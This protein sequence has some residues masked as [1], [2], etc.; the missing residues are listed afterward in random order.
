MAKSDGKTAFSV[1]SIMVA[2]FP[3]LGASATVDANAPV[4]PYITSSSKPLTACLVDHL[5][6][7][8]ACI[9]VVEKECL[10]PM[11]DT[12]T[13][14]GEVLC[15]DTEREIWSQRLAASAT[16]MRLVGHWHGSCA[17]AVCCV[18][19]GSARLRLLN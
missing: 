9:G 13:L 11:E 3:C 6:S 18:K 5:T 7:P 1:T 19:P 17:P 8:R 15:A 14:W 16:Q 12:Q 10:K 2:A 4:R